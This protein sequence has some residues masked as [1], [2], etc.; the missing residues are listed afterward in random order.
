MK[1]EKNSFTLTDLLLVI[2]IILALVIIF[3]PTIKKEMVITTMSVGQ[4]EPEVESAK[5]YV[6]TGKWVKNHWGYGYV[7]FKDIGPDEA[8]DQVFCGD[9]ISP[10]IEFDPETGYSGEF[11]FD[12]N[13]PDWDEWL[14]RFDL[15][16]EEH[17][18]KLKRQNVRQ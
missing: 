6:V 15:A 3:I 16:L 11:I 18:K 10:F 9:K 12:P 4:P 5:F 1:E 7:Q 17:A 14:K 8:L 13:S 2:I